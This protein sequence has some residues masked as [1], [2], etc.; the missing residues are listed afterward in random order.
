MNK[1]EIFSYLNEL[2]LRYDREAFDKF[3]RKSKLRMPCPSVHVVGS[4]GKTATASYLSA[5]LSAAGRKTGLLTNDIYFNPLDAISFNNVSIGEQ[6]FASLFEDSRKLYEKYGLSRW[7]ILVDIA[8]RFFKEKGAEII[9]LES[10]LGGEMDASFLEDDD[11][12]LLVLTSVG[13]EH[14]EYLGTTISQIALNKISGLSNEAPLLTCEL[15]E[16]TLNVVRDYARDVN[17][18]VVIADAYHHQHL[19]QGRFH[20]DF[21]EYK[22]MMIPSEAEFLVKDACLAIQAASMLDKQFPVSK[23]SVFN[24]LSSCILPGILERR[25]NIVFDNADNPDSVNALLRSFQTLSEGKPIQILFASEKDKNIAVMLPTLG[26]GAE[27]ITLTTY[28]GKN[29]RDEK[30]FFLYSGD[31]PFV[32]DPLVA[33][34]QIEKAHPEAAIL[35]TG[36]KAFVGYMKE[37]IQ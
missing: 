24:G 6:E 29:V 30:G 27:S 19:V 14:T 32:A 1:E 8:L 10:S 23:E 3:A 35:I 36:S 37:H 5:I 11:M 28:P 20:F 9:V 31:Y 33:L 16:D 2:P 18:D 7:E 12:R 22:D 25:G 4:N 17:S 21:G 15:E 13:L 34:N 26:N